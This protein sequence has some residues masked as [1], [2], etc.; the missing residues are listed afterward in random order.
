[1]K[2]DTKSMSSAVLVF[3][4][5]II[6]Q[7]FQKYPRKLGVRTNIPIDIAL[8]SIWTWRWKHSLDDWWDIKN[9]NDGWVWNY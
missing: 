4:S 1:M 5:N 7:W 2:I 8:I 6:L 3:G 9:F